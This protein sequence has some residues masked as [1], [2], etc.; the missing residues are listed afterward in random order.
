MVEVIEVVLILLA[1]ILVIRN[2]MG[3]HKIL[4]FGIFQSILLSVLYLVPTSVGVVRFL[5]GV[6]ESLLYKLALILGGTDQEEIVA[7]SLASQDE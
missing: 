3:L 7:R 6:I 2:T 5:L 4:K 1:V